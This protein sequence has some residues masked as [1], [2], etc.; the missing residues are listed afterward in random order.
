MI[1]CDPEYYF[2]WRTITSSYDALSE[3]APVVYLST[4]TEIGVVESVRKKCRDNRFN[5]GREGWGS[6]K[7]EGF[8]EN[9]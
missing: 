2:Y 3:I 4:D 6:E 9:R 5:F 8:E 7:M 1:E